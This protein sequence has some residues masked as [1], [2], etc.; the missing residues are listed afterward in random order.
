MALTHQAPL[1]PVISGDLI[2]R[3]L[4]PQ[5]LKLADAAGARVNWRVIDQPLITHGPESGEL[6]EELLA[7]I[8]EA[9][10][11]LKGSFSTP[12]GVGKLSPSVM[13]RKRLNLFA[14]VRYIRHLKGLP[15]RYEDLDFVIVRENT[16][17]VYAGLEHT[18]YPGVVESI[19]VVTRQASER[20]FHFAYQLAQK[21]GQSQVAIIHKANIMKRSDGL[22]LSVGREVG[23]HYPELNTRDLIVDNTCMQMVMRPEQFEVI[24]CGNLYGDI[25][26]DLG[27][28]LVGGVSATWGEDHGDDV[29]VFSTIHAQDSHLMGLDVANPLPILMPTIALLRYLGQDEAADRLREATESVLSA[30][31]HL[32]QDLGGTASTGEMIRALHRALLR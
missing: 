22:F 32:T 20:V 13:L 10:V 8:Q 1:V 3:E 12:D 25:L 27:A 23:A 5:V 28:G 9:G 6:S 2:D 31:V 19:K 4:L 15:S 14:G 29:K 18:V 7:M 21:R 17:D 16:E 30:K 24:V 11:A 26:S